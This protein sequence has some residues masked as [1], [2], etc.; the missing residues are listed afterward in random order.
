M[1]RSLTVSLFVLAA[2]L[3]SPGCRKSTGGNDEDTGPRIE[4]MSRSPV[5]IVITADP[6]TVDLRKD[7]LLNITVT[8]PSEID[9]ALPDLDDRLTGFALNGMFDEEPVTRQGR[10]TLE[11]KARLSPLLSDEYR[12]APMAIRYVDR[13]RSPAR[14]SWFPT[15]PMVFDTVS[16]VQGR[17]ARDI[18]DSM[19]PVW[20][21]PPFKT[22]AGYVL[23][24]LGITAIIAL[25][26]KFL[27]KLHRKIRLM[28]MSP[29]ELALHQLSELLAK[30]L[31]AKD[32][33]K[34][35]YLELTMIVRRYIERAHRVRAPEQTT[36][37]FLDAVTYDHRFSEEVVDKLKTF[38]QAADLVKFAAYHP[39]TE[40]IGRA[41]DTAR[42]YIETDAETRITTEEVESRNHPEERP[43]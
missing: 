27:R 32:M 25:A 36:E 4:D 2:I 5:E 21:H 1:I 41:T 30:D 31:P 10:T 19:R 18:D 11:R 34:E 38:L 43:E 22:V 24:V 37:E 39:E 7:I 3:L 17:S 9:V 12:L 13:S 20:I 35:F 6:A 26:W 29:R 42:N 33:V 23:L 8:A 15:R 28:R 14:S 40:A 16:S